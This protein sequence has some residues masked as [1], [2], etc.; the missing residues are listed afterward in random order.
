MTWLSFI[1]MLGCIYVIIRLL[2]VTSKSSTPMLVF[3]HTAFN[4][5]VISKCPIFNEKYVPTFLWGKSGHIQTILYGKV[6]RVRTPWPK[7]ERFSVVL[8]DGAT[9]TYDVFEP[10]IKNSTSGDF[11][12]AVCP[13][14]ANSSRSIYIRT[15]V[16]YAQRNGFRVAVLNHLGALLDVPLTAPRI[17]TYGGTEEY[18]AVIDRLVTSYPTSNIIAVGFSMG[19]NIVLKYLGEDVNNQAKVIGAVSCCQGYDVIRAKPLLLGWEQCRRLYI[20]AMTA[21]QKSILRWHSGALFGVGASASSPDLASKAH[22]LSKSSASAPELKSTSASSYDLK[23]IFSAATM[24]ELDE[25]YSRRRAGFDT[26]DD[27]Y[28]WVSSANYMHTINIPV[29]LLNALDD[30]IV[31]NELLEIPRQFALSRDKTIFV[32]TQHGGHLG[33]FEGGLV[34]P[35]AVTWLDRVVVQY[36]NALVSTLAAIATV[37]A[38]GNKKFY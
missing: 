1:L 18:S 31:P 2:N 35:N 20:W 17:F 14:I 32:A 12:L 13:G 21:H 33:F 7:G 4:D 36:T 30:P 38:A 9:V 26:V 29:F 28:H 25:H 10:L 11:T 34:Y 16:D 37:E 8:R 3:K 23:R 19:A 27:Y 6:G 24:N 22:S 5:T 15:F